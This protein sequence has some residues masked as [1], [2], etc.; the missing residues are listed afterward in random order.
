SRLFFFSTH[1]AP[2][3]LSTLSLHDALPISLTTSS[4]THVLYVDATVDVRDNFIAS[5]F[6]AGGSADNVYVPDKNGT[7]FAVVLVR[8]YGKRS[9]EHTSELQSLAYL[10]CRLLLEKKNTK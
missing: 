9:E 5:S 6:S 2:T 1:T 3:Y 7:K 4:Y 8:R 10:V